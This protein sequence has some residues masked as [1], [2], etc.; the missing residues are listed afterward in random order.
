[1][2]NLPMCFGC[3]GSDWLRL[4]LLPRQPVTALPRRLR[5]IAVRALATQPG[6]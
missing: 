5:V 4:P 6:S 1:M 2:A 3:H